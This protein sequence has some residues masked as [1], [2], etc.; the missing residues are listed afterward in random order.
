[1]SLSDDDTEVSTVVAGNTKAATTRRRD[2]CFTEFDMLKIDKIWDESKMRYL[3]MGKEKCP[4]T[5][6]EHLQGYV[7]FNNAVSFKGVKRY[8]SASTHVEGCRGNSES[9]IN[10]CKKE[11]DFIEFGDKPQ[12]GRRND[13]NKVGESIIKGEFDPVKFPSEFIK[14]SGGIKKFE[15][16]IDNQKLLDERK[17]YFKD[18]WLGGCS[19]EILDNISYWEE[20]MMG[21]KPRE[22]LWIFT[23]EGNRGKSTFAEKLS[24]FNDAVVF[25]TTNKDSVAYAISSNNK[26]VIFDLSRSTEGCINYDTLECLCNRRITSKKYE[27]KVKFLRVDKVIV[28]SNYEPDVNKLSADRLRVIGSLASAAHDPPTSAPQA[29]PC[30]AAWPP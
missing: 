1:M 29:S 5:G 28:C 16:Y 27:S 4:T 7:Y 13:L 17:V 2:W 12:Q 30:G 20:N 14:Y 22:I 21:L 3:V 18:V 26:V 8:L 9:N 23:K 25:D 10:Y 11:G 19:K 6:K 24:L 15:E